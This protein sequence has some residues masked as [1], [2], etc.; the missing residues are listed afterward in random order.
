MIRAVGGG[1]KQ[2]TGPTEPDYLPVWTKAQCAGLPAV[3]TKTSRDE[4]SNP[5][6]QIFLKKKTNRSWFICVAVGVFP[7]CA[8][9]NMN[10][11]QCVCEG[12]AQSNTYRGPYEG[13]QFIG[14]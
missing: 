7:R 1:R 5:L 11:L 13:E 10:L 4:D 6:K 12:W 9:M 2:V 8:P 14:S 3:G